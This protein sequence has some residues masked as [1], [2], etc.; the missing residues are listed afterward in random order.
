VGIASSI[1]EIY[2]DDRAPLQLLTLQ[3]PLTQ[4]GCNLKMGCA[5]CW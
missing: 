4:V 3:A 1:S 5:Y 2:Y